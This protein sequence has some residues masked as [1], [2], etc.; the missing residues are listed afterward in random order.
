MPNKSGER[1]AL[2]FLLG[3][4]FGG[5]LV[6]LL[7]SLKL[8]DVLERVGLREVPPEKKIEK[9]RDFLERVEKELGE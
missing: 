1:M 7:S 9:T 6:V 5:G 2:I 8:E 4:A 3:L